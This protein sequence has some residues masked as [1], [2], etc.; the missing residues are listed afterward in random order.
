MCKTFICIGL[1]L[2][3]IFDFGWNFPYIIFDQGSLERLHQVTGGLTTGPE[4]DQRLVP[5]TG[6]KPKG[7]EKH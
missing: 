1:G 3:K 7:Q 4:V 5:L 2:A 6:D